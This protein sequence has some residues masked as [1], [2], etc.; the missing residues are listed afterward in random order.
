MD[1]KF[2]WLSVAVVWAVVV[3]DLGRI[4]SVERVIVKNQVRLET[5]SSANS[6]N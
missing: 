3:M 1:Y 2:F 4:S 6:A 5:K